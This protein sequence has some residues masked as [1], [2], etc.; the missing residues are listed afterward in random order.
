MLSTE[1]RQ[2]LYERAYLPEHLPDYVEAVS[3]G[4]TYLHGEY[5]CISRRNHL[6]FI[7]YALKDKEGDTQ[8]AYASAC[9]RF[10][11]TTVAI[12]APAIWLP[13]GSYEPQPQDHY[14]RLDLPLKSISAGVA[15]MLRRADREI[16]VMPGN[17]GK[18]H[19]RLVKS[20][21]SGRQLTREQREVFKGI[22]AYLKGSRSAR[23]IEARKG[24]RLVAFNIVD[25][26]SAHYAFYLFNFRSAKINVPGSSDLLFHE[27]VRLAHAEGKS[28][29]NLGLGINPGV[30]RFKE[31]WGATPFL[32]YT[33]ATIRRHALELAPLMKKL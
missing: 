12:I 10:H 1:E 8:R 19:Q 27:M 6:I 15:Y 18:E 16:D 5:L 25:L 4:E 2:F 23:L 7:G 9:A 11:P 33:S 13:P 30:R 20:F 26:G 14:F 24:D 28:A 17:F 32:I 29:M 31:K 22:P 3:G 21:L